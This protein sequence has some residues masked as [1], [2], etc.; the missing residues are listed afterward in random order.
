MCGSCKLLV[1]MCVVELQQKFNTH[2]SYSNHSVI[3]LLYTSASLDVNDYF[4]LNLYMYVL[5]TI[6]VCK[7]LLIHLVLSVCMHV[8]KISYAGSL[9]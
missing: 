6:T 7:W 4:V 5:Y 9:Q 2:I 8:F 3:L 1:A